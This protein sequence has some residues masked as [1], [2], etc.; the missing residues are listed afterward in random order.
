[1]TSRFKLPKQRTDLHE[2]RYNLTVFHLVITKTTL[3]M[4]I[5]QSVLT[6][7][8]MRGHK[9]LESCYCLLFSVS[10]MVYENKFENPLR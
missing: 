7:Q 9:K 4:H 3:L 8:W 2:F 6:E 10:A 5:L 1:M